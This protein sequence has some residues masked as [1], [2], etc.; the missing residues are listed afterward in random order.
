MLTIRYVDSLSVK[1]SEMYS[2]QN[3]TVFKI[4]ENIVMNLINKG[5]D[6]EIINEK[7]SLNVKRITELRKKLE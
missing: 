1:A 7:T 6:N 4:K 5:F 3:E 2:I